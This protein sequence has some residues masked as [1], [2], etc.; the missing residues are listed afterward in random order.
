MR[1][2]IH[3]QPGLDHHFQ[4]AELFAEG[5]RKHGHDVEI[6]RGFHPLNRDLALVWGGSPRTKPVVDAQIA[7][8]RPYITMER[9]FVGDR[10]KYTSIG[11][12]GFNGLANYPDALEL[13][14]R[15]EIPMDTWKP[16]KELIVIM[17]QMAGDAS[18]RGVDIR[19]WYHEMAEEAGDVFG[20]KFKVVFRAHPLDKSGWHPA[21]APRI[22]GA[23]DKVL[24]RAKG[25]ITYSSTSAIDSLFAGVPVMA[26]NEVS[27]A[28]D[29]AANTVK[30]LKNMKEPDR[31]K[32]ALNL[33]YCQWTEEEIAS[34]KAWEHIEKGL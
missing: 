21:N 25:V 18:L 15:F 17:G 5:A 6:V 24:R 26:A 27:M 28:Y 20:K 30:E 22:G 3:C 9:G 19:P 29:V 11:L 7:A 10:M 33:S 31:G 12:N 34:G 32:F 23:L 8:G 2:A 14:P 1:I 4:Y 13:S 16:G